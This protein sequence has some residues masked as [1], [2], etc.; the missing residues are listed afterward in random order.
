VWT[1]SDLELN[2]AESEGTKAMGDPRPLTVHKQLI[3]IYF[4]PS[5]VSPA[6]TVL[7]QVYLLHIG[8]K[9]GALRFAEAKGQ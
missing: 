9:Q 1:E 7:K 3:R 4:S 5:L 2:E 6:D 8:E